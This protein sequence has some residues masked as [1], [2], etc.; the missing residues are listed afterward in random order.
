[1]RAFYRELFDAFEPETAVELQLV[2]RAIGLMW[3]L[4]RV[5]GFEADLF[6]WS[7]RI[8]VAEDELWASQQN[9]VRADNEPLYPLG[10]ILEKMLEKDSLDKL[11][12]YQKSQHKQ[13][14]ETLK[15]LKE[16][17]GDRILSR[18]PSPTASNAQSSLPPA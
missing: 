3:C 14:I 12:R 17:Q 8:L 15:L 13:L 18:I 2:E 10:R 7:R 9:A 1:L 4:R 16:I 5:P 6:K 11:D